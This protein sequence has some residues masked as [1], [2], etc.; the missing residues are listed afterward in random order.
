MHVNGFGDT[1]ITAALAYENHSSVTPYTRD[2]VNKIHEDVRFGRAFV[3][4]LRL[5]K[6]NLGL[7]LST[8]A[9]VA[10]TSKTRIIH[11]LTLASS[12]SC[13]GVDADTYFAMA[14]PCQLVHVLRDV[15]RLMLYLRRKHGVSARI[16][17]SKIEVKEAFLDRWRWSGSSPRRLHT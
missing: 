14:P 17:L 12:A 1:D 3:F 7:R 2:I 13:H 9:V 4:P 6:G 8:L 16:L 10:S 11:D 5:A 15:V